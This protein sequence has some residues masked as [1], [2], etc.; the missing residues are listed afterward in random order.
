MAGA[1]SVVAAPAAAPIDAF[2]RK[3]RR[4]IL[5]PYGCLQAQPSWLHRF[6]TNLRVLT[7]GQL[8]T[9]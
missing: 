3:S 1:A 8:K 9:S 7:R 5:S 4:C 6:F 2:L